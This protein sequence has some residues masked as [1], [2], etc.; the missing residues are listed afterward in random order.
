MLADLAT[1]VASTDGRQMIAER[2][3]ARIRQ[4]KMGGMMLDRVRLMYEFYRDAD[5]PIKP[6]LLIGAALLY[7]V[8]PNDLIPDWFALVGFAD[9]FAAIAYVYS[10]VRD[11][12]AN[13]DER[14]QQRLAAWRGVEEG[15]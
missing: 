14:R 4:S 10:Q 5:E 12:L 9:D 1:L 3:E 8:I 7:L 6:K 11:V 13:Y 15:A 2:L